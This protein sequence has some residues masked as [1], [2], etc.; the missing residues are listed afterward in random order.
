TSGPPA[1]TAVS[2]HHAADFRAAS[3]EKDMKDTSPNKRRAKW[4]GGALVAIGTV[5]AAVSGQVSAQ[6]QAPGATS[7]PSECAAEAAALPGNPPQ[8]PA[9]CHGNPH[10]VTDG[11]T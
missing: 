6:S 11:T 9:A 5:G 3:R 10:F 8:H 2:Q 1:C 4:I 7:L